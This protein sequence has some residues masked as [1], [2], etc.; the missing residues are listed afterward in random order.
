MSM[1]GLFLAAG[2]GERLKPLTDK[3]HK[4][5]LP[6]VN[7]APLLDYWV[8]KLGAW[9]DMD[10]IFV[11]ICLHK[12]KIINHLEKSLPI[13]LFKKLE[14]VIWDEDKMVPTGDA[15]VR[16]SNLLPKDSKLIIVNVDTYIPQ[17]EIDSFVRANSIVWEKWPIMLGATYSND[18]RD[19]GYIKFREEDHVITSFKEKQERVKTGH[20]WSGI[21]MLYN[22]IIDDSF[23][24]DPI[25]IAF[26]RKSFVNQMKAYPIN[27]ALDIG[28]SLEEYRRIY[29]KLSPNS[30]NHKERLDINDKGVG[31]HLFGGVKGDHVSRYLFAMKYAMDKDVLDLG[32][33]TGYGIKFMS[34]VAKSIVGIDKDEEVVKN[35]KDLDSAQ[36]QCNV[37]F[38]IVNLNTST[39]VNYNAG[40]YDLITAFEFVEHVRHPLNLIKLAYDSLRPGGILIAS[41]PNEA[42][43]GR[44]VS[45]YHNHIF[46]LNKLRLIMESQF[47][48]E[49]IEYYGQRQTY[50]STIDVDNAPYFVAIG[51]K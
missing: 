32:C 30:S 44:G 1:Y 42:Q 9:H 38:Q 8:W 11:S 49:N 45:I 25:S 14:F 37:N 10:K 15:V 27:T 4:A 6:V 7:D 50:F 51:K 35:Y 19:Q 46:D 5:L 39:P 16:V 40:Q 3:T 18:I 33:G 43:E 23:K 48:P 29:K 12:D 20:F 31:M 47:K 22:D 24:G 13:R 26:G 2:K 21:A 36:T 41:V 17:W 34:Y 28:K